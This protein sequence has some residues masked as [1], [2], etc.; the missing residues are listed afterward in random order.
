MNFRILCYIICMKKCEISKKNVIRA[1]LYVLL[2]IL[3]YVIEK[4][5]RTAARSQIVF[6]V[7]DNPLPAHSLTGVFSSLSI[8]V[9]ILTVVFYRKLGFYTSMVILSYRIF[10]LFRGILHFR[11]SSLPGFFTV[12]CGTLAII[13]IY[14]KSEQR[15]KEHERHKK[16]LIDF[17]NS[18][19]D[20]FSVCIDGKDSYT[21]GHSLRV[22]KYTRMLAQ[23]LGED[24]E[25]CG[26]FYNIA[27]LH[28][29]GKIGIPD[30]ILNKPGKL[31]EEEYETVKTHTYRGFEILRR[32]KSEKDIAD[33]AQHHHERFDGKGYPAR[34]SGEKIPW[35]AR[36]ISV[37][38][39]FDAMNSS[40]PYRKKLPMKDIL[41][42]IQICS[43][44]QFDPKVT[45]AFMELY[46]EGAFDGI[47]TE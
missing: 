26:K 12:L 1:V 35:V 44:T 7:F 45:K 43:G 24:E 29:I 16:E 6:N 38:D 27:L 22:A 34:L 21:N 23:K 40:R 3:Y 11:A 33:G 31:T 37:A 13:I 9:L 8:M 10:V 5:T 46:D 4:G 14:N 19:I 15:I 41:K 36:I 2:I 47:R 42:E 20:S 18:I 32:V 30:E 17:T 28:D 39:A 25:T